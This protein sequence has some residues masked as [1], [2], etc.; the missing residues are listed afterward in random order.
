MVSSIICSSDYLKHYEP[1]LESKAAKF[2]N[3]CN[4]FK[5]DIDCLRK[6]IK[7]YYVEENFDRT[8]DPLPVFE[9]VNKEIRTEYE[10][11]LRKFDALG[12]I[13]RLLQSLLLYTKSEDDDDKCLDMELFGLPF[14]EQKPVLLKRINNLK[15][16]KEL[17]KKILKKLEDELS[18]YQDKE[19]KMTL[20]AINMTDLYKS[21][22]KPVTILEKDINNEVTRIKDAFTKKYESLFLIKLKCEKL[23]V[24]MR[25][26]L[27]P[28]VTTLETSLM[29][30]RFELEKVENET[31]ETVRQD[32][33]Q[34][35]IDDEYDKKMQFLIKDYDKV[36]EENH[37]MTSA[38][39]H[40]KE[41]LIRTFRKK[42][43][44]TKKIF[45]ENLIN[46]GQNS[47]I[48]K[49]LSEVQN[50]NL[51]CDLC[52]V[53]NSTNNQYI[54]QDVTIINLR[55][56]ICRMIQMISKTNN[57]INVLENDLK[58]LRNE[59]Q[60]YGIGH[61]YMGNTIM[62]SKTQFNI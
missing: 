30:K 42:N 36:V 18:M 12:K 49:R 26:I 39:E 28:K 47:A 41:S 56:Q 59:H 1:Y 23:D 51:N 19:R 45:A 2:F 7:K 35:K 43:K 10:N 40:M 48:D 53:K 24:R 6:V 21:K 38:I 58:F 37:S 57:F 29:V 25:E 62:T 31:K 9:N 17:G 13:E 52:Y 20:S 3:N 55:E 46:F 14:N 16:C 5:S 61:D 22:L 4:N 11:Q 44:L 34:M 27:L 8:E 50:N 32:N 54:H 15:H 60:K 33:L